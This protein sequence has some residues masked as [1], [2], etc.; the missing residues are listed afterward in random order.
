MDADSILKNANSTLIDADFILTNADSTLMNF[1]QKI[2][3]P[4]DG[5]PRFSKKDFVQI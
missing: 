4:G 3:P 5:Y 1:G 2:F